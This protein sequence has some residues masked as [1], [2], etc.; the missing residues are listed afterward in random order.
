MKQIQK[1]IGVIALAGIFSLKVP[2]QE[3]QMAIPHI[4]HVSTSL[5]CIEMTNIVFSHDKTVMNFRLKSGTDSIII[6]PDAFIVEDGGIRHGLLETDKASGQDRFIIRK[7]NECTLCFEPC[8]KKNTKCIDFYNGGD[9]MMIGIH[10]SRTPLNIPEKEYRMTAHEVD[11]SMFLPGRIEISG[12]VRNN[13][14]GKKIYCQYL[15]FYT[16]SDRAD[17][18]AA[19]NDDGTFHLS[20]AADHPGM[21]AFFCMDEESDVTHGD[22]D[23]LAWNI[24]ARPGDKLEMDFDINKYHDFDIRNLS[25]RPNYTKLSL[26]GLNLINSVSL[27]ASENDDLQKGRVE[28]REAYKRNRELAKYIIWHYGFSDTEAALYLDKLLFAYSSGMGSINIQAIQRVQ[29]ERT[30][31]E[32]DW[33]EDTDSLNALVDLSYLK[34][35]D[36]YNKDYFCNTDFHNAYGRVPPV[37]EQIRKDV[38]ANHKDLSVAEKEVRILHEQN[39]ALNKI[40]GWKGLTNIAQAMYVYHMYQIRG[41]N[42]F[43]K[44]STTA[45]LEAIQN[46]LTHPYLINSAKEIY[47]EYVLDGEIGNIN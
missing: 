35:L 24:Y 26:Y 30:N 45:P 6:N 23:A 20:F 41:S 17:K 32:L 19:V 12:K 42:G 34:E 44:L 2:A 7:G 13:G 9:G 14:T 25:G 10:D 18:Y 47:D 46:E 43:K 22:A 3:I 1:F 36:P 11:N 8:I 5:E 21:L 33:L 38:Y 39:E 29:E 28:I 15:H 40:T 37:F 27:K 31:R 16:D 4:I